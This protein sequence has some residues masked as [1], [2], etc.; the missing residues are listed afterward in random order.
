MIKIKIKFFGI[1]NDYFNNLEIEVKKN[2]SLYE[3]KN[4]II[5]NHVD[6]TSNHLIDTIK[7][8]LFAINNKVIKENNIIKKSC[9]IYLLP[10]FSGG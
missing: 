3:L 6:N 10:P 4:M 5:N 9:I 7:N 1:L 2:I 8:S